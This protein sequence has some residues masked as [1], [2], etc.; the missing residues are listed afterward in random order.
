MA[1]EGTTRPVGNDRV[2]WG[3][4]SVRRRRDMRS[5][6]CLFRRAGSSGAERSH[7]NAVPHLLQNFSGVMRFRG[8]ET[9]PQPRHTRV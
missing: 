4:S 7:P 5:T 1:A 3:G 2:D 6:A 9:F 8:W